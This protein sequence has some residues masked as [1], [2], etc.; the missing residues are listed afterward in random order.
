MYS[1]LLLWL[2]R[3]RVVL[4]YRRK[5]SS[6]EFLA[7][8]FRERHRHRRNA[9][10]ELLKKCIPAG[11]Y[12]RRHGVIRSSGN[13]RQSGDC[14]ASTTPPLVCAPLSSPPPSLRQ[15]LLSTRPDV[16]GHPLA[17]PVPILT[18]PIAY[19]VTRLGID[20]LERRAGPSPQE[21]LLLVQFRRP[22]SSPFIITS[23]LFT[24]YRKL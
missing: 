23:G 13:I 8:S 6:R 17:Y 16:Y 2:F 18:Y 15:P 5:I 3:M 12:P 21:R 24:S 1:V 9:S 20:L 7:S 11:K 19:P 22:S 4:P 14:A 10:F